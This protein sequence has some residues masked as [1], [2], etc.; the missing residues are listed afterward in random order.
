[1]VGKSWRMFQL[2][3]NRLAA[4]GRLYATKYQKHRQGNYRNSYLFKDHLIELRAC[5]SPPLPFLPGCQLL[6]NHVISIPSE[7][8]E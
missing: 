5:F 3:N 7:K 4:V 1:M 2:G 8:C 6:Q